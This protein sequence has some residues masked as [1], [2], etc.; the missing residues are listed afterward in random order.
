MSFAWVMTLE[1]AQKKLCV[2]CF[3][4][5]KG[6]IKGGA[7]AYALPPG[8]LVHRYQRKLNRLLGFPAFN[9]KLMTITVPGQFRNDLYRSELELKTLVPHECILG[10]VE[11]A[12]REAEVRK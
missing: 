6:G 3:W 2:L 10:E 8:K 5:V 9:Q 1:F 7:S 4:V 12:L 11:E